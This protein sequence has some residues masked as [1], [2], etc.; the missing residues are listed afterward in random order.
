[1]VD[2]L[3]KG[4]DWDEALISSDALASVL[5][6]YTRPAKYPDRRV[7]EPAAPAA[8]VDDADDSELSPERQAEL[9]ERRSAEIKEAALAC[10]GQSDGETDRAFVKRVDAEL[11]K[12]G[13]L[14][15]KRGCFI[16]SRW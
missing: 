7:S 5:A 3:Y 11:V 14:P 8:I 9:D 2:D 13:H 1:M 12:R 15:I 6:K 10:G 16:T 4:E